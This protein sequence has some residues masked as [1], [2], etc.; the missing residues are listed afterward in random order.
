[1]YLPDHF[2]VEDRGRLFDIIRRNPLAMLATSGPGGLLVN[3]VPMLL[4]EQR[5]VL[6]GHVARANPVWRDLEQGIECVAAFQGEDYY[7][8]PNWYPS[9]AH[10]HKVVPTWNYVMVQVRGKTQTFHDAAWLRTLVGDL[11]TRHESAQPKPWAVEDAPVEFVDAQLR[12]IVGVEIAIERIDGKF[13]VSQNRTAVDRE[14]VASHLST[15]G[16][17]D[18]AKLVRELGGKI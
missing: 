11:T 5:N 10:T 1:M 18:S 13:K 3:A 9:K 2:R 17:A 8:S 16:K 14:G 6:R 12:A 4:D 15:D 7:V